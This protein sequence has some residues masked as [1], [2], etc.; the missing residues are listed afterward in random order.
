MRCRFFPTHPSLVF[1][2]DMVFNIKKLV[3]TGVMG[4]LLICIVR[5]H[6]ILLY[7]GLEFGMPTPLVPTPVRLVYNLLKLIA[8]GQ[9]PIASLDPM[10]LA[11]DKPITFSCGPT[12][13]LITQLH[14]KINHGYPFINS[15]N[16]GLGCV[17]LLGPESSL[18]F[19]ILTGQST[20]PP[21]PVVTYRWRRLYDGTDQRVREYAAV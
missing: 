5:L 13:C 12:S 3:L 16:R 8:R 1:S 2:T 9:S 15:P 17:C 6:Q 14:S 7:V 19:W 11:S 20:L 4:H 21:Y 10:T 18:S